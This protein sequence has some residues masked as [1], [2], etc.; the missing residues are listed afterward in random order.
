ML[1]QVLR[2]LN[3]DPGVGLSDAEVAE[4]SSFVFSLTL[5][6]C[7][8]AATLAAVVQPACA[9]EY[10]HALSMEAMNSHLKKVSN[11]SSLVL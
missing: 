4:V 1:L 3:V 5:C 10:R 9:T 2:L 8:G 6:Y 7:S 11:N